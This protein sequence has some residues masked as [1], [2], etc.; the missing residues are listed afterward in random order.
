MESCDGA[1]GEIATIAISSLKRVLPGTT[2]SLVAARI[3]LIPFGSRW[4]LNLLCDPK[5]HTMAIRYCIRRTSAIPNNV[6]ASDPRKC[7]LIMQNAQ[8]YSLR[9]GNEAA[10]AACPSIYRTQPYFLQARGCHRLNA[11]RRCRQ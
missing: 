8:P 6:I 2:L 1:S 9:R 3:R 11:K 10:S 5:T 7:A 4:A